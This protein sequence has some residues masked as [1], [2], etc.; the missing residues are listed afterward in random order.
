MNVEKT[1]GQS[2]ELNIKPIKIIIPGLIIVMIL[3]VLFTFN[4]FQKKNVI[5][6]AENVTNQMAEYIAGNIANEIEFA[7]SSIRLSAVTIAQTMTSDTLENPAD[8]ILPMVSNTPFGSIEYIRADGMNIMNIGEPF[9]ASDREYYIEGIKGNTGIWN[10]YHPKTSKETL[11]NFYTP[12][13]Y[14]DSISGVITGYIEATTQIS[15][16]FETKLYGKTIHGILLDENNM[17]ICSTIK[18]DY[19]KD[20]T[21]DMFME[22]FNNMSAEYIKKLAATINSATDTAMSYKDPDG[23]GHISTVTIPGTQWKVV[24]L[25]PAGSFNEIISEN[26]RSAVITIAV[27]GLILT[28]YAAAVLMNNV[29][30]RREIALENIRL[31]EEN[32]IFDDENRR[33]F[34]K[35]TEMRDIIASAKM[36]TWR[37]ELVEGEGPR[38]YV[39]ETM[40]ELLGI[41][42]QEGTPEQTYT[43]WFGKIKPEALDSVLHSV[44]EMEKGNFDENTY[45][46]IHP[47]KGTR[48]VRCGGTSQEIPGGYL[49]RGYHYDVDEVVRKEQNQMVMLQEALNQKNEYYST[50]GCLGDVFYSMHVIDL[51]ENTTVEFSAR[52]EVKKI[53]NHRDGAIDMM[54]E[55]ISAVT[56]DEYKEAALS[57]TDLTTLSGR[58]KNKQIIS[59]QLIGKNIGWFLAS[60]ITMEADAEGR[61]TKVIFTTRI[62]DEEKK[63]EEQLIKKSQTDEMTGLLNRRAYEEDIYEHNDMPD[64]EE[65]TYIS[66]DANGLKVLNDSKGHMAG[67][68]MLIGVCQCMKKV[69]GA[70]GKLYRIGGDEFVVILYKGTDRVNELLAAFDAELAGW[71][72]KLVDELSVSYGWINKEEEPG[73]SVRQLGAVAE[74]RMYDAKSD[75]YKKTGV[76]RCGQ[77]DAHK[78]LCELYTKILKI[79]VSDDSYHIVNLDVEEQTADK[80]FSNKISEWL[81]AFGESGQVHPDD[82]QDYLK[83]TS[84]DYIKSYFSGEKTSLHIFYRRRFRDTFKHVMMELIPANDYAKDNQSFFLYVKEIDK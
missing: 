67:D 29:K 52:N 55:V 27:I 13:R 3:T 70:Y 65:F 40:R 74:E 59:K 5:K 78:A 2:T 24:I 83:Y 66:M 73:F 64:T 72:G 30:R 25:V 60:F 58:M 26:T 36:G 15:P 75:H 9:D 44:E 19:V 17:V 80:G 7:K 69:F 68:E 56:E 50:L 43:D 35:L 8:I 1:G 11:M 37:I 51:V 23:E 34:S 57:F 84:I 53:V 38:M 31:E 28:L 33:V 21:L 62:N 47:E 45:L 48:Y 42:G 71:K 16:L 14:G 4:Y 63:Q 22:R 20:L 54:V 41:K 6:N 82:L 79:N 32:H 18:A 49:L 12:L 39:D 76:D 77:Q 10:N 61:P 81:R 46:W